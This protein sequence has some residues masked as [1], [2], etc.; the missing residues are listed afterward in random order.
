RW[1]RQLPR[2]TSACTRCT[3][4]CGPC[5]RRRRE[6]RFSR[7]TTSASSTR[8]GATPAPGR[9]RMWVSSRVLTESHWRRRS[10]MHSQIRHAPAQLFGSLMAFTLA[11]SILPAVRPAHAQDADKFEVYGFGHFDYIQDF[12][13][14]DP[15]WAATLRPSKIP[16]V[17]RTFGSDGQAILSVRQSRLGAQANLPTDNGTVFAKAEFDL[18]GVGADAG[19][20]TIRPRHMYGQW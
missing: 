6:R 4:P 14:V 8:G 9:R 5:S 15:T 12:K 19:Q 7:A 3:S 18:F 13:R 11:L 1:R 17:A 10:G 20:T 16:T 2:P